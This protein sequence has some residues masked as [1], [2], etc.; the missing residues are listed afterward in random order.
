MENKEYKLSFIDTLAMATGF[1]VGSG[2]I[3]QTGIGIAMTG[4]SI[5][6]AFGVSAI[7]FLICFRPVFIM[8][9]VL[10]RNGASYFYCTHL[11]GKKAGGLYAYMYLLGRITIAIF[12]ISFAEYLAFLVP[13]LSG[14]IARRLVAIG[15][16]TFFY[17]VNLFGLRSAAKFQ[18]IMCIILLSGLLLFVFFGLGNVGNDFFTPDSFFTNGFEGFYSAVSLLFFAVGGAYIITDFAPSIK[19][20]ENIMT[21]VIFIVTICVCIIYMLLGVVASGV[22]PVNEVAGKP[23]TLVAQTIFPNKALFAVFIV[24]ACLGALVTTLNSSFVWYSNSLL[25]A[26]YDGWLPM[27][28]T[29]CNKNGV[30]YRMMSLFYIVGVFFAIIDIDLA[31]LSKMAIGLTILS[32]CIPMIGIIN[33]PKKYPKEWNESKYAKRY[34][35]WR[36]YLM[37]MITCMVMLTQVLSLFK[38]NPPLA[39]IIIVVYILLVSVY[40]ILKK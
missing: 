23:L 27:W 11:I 40:L 36:I 37:A 26:C 15:V 21:K 16:L 39:N 33:L 29:K 22:M 12:G 25:R 6:P 28:L 38:S 7:L 17:V 31:V 4:R 9:S 35:M 13:A 10:P 34:P 30:A 19:N 24:G 14:D 5:F 1:T 8:S 20:A 2:I 3:T 32:T 18:N